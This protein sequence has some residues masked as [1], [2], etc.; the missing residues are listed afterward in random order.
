[1]QSC[2]AYSVSFLTRLFHTAR[3][4][5]FIVFIPFFFC[6]FIIAYFPL[7]FCWIGRVMFCN[8]I[9][10]NLVSLHDWR[11]FLFPQWLSIQSWVKWMVLP[12]IS[13]LCMFLLVLLN[14]LGMDSSCQACMG[15][16]FKDQWLKFTIK[17]KL[18]L[19]TKT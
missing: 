4:S 18:R 13:S 9:F 16:I 8:N 5:S 19:S 12:I 7:G 6:F 17:Q 2:L 10:E 15:E 11:W 1:M 3:V 14:R